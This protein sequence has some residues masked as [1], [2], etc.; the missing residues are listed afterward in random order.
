MYVWVTQAVFTLRGDSPPTYT[1][2]TSCR[3]ITCSNICLLGRARTAGLKI[4]KPTKNLFFNERF[5]PNLNRTWIKCEASKHYFC[6]DGATQWRLNNVLSWTELW[7]KLLIIHSVMDRAWF[8]SR[9]RKSA[10]LSWYSS[11]KWSIRGRN[12][13]SYETNMACVDKLAWMDFISV[14]CLLLKQ[15]KFGS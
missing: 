6:A 10:G 7:A 15:G 1:K 2:R 5:N 9:R 3:F 11:L 13:L 4:T 14:A 12:P 8:P